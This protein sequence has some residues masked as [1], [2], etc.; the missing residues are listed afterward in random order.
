MAVG[1]FP[2]WYRMTY[3]PH[4]IAQSGSWGRRKS[5]L[6]VSRDVTRMMMHAVLKWHARVAIKVGVAG[7]AGVAGV[8]CVVG[9]YT[10]MF[11]GEVK[12]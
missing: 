3:V 5:N 8:M 10:F 6:I 2:T 11:W 4:P 12:K 1:K 7:V 9:V